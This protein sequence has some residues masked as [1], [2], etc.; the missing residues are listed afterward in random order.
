MYF[1]THDLSIYYEKYGDKK[2]TI[3]ILPG[4]GYTRPSFYYLIN[5]L[6][7]NYTVYIIDYPGFGNSSLPDTDLTIYDYAEIVKDFINAHLHQV[8]FLA[9]VKKTTVLP[10][11]FDRSS[12][13]SDHLDRLD[14]IVL[15]I[16]VKLFIERASCQNFNIADV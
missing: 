16:D 10:G 7:V 13:E 1:K 11:F 6:Q 3:L 4:W 9:F 5:F 15:Q 14:R 12:F 2:P 8:R